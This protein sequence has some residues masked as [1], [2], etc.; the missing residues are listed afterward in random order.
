M[1]PLVLENKWLTIPVNRSAQ[2]S[3]LM[4]DGSLPARRRFELIR[5]AQR[6][7]QL[8]VAELSLQFGVSADTIRR[9]LDLLSVHGFCNSCSSL[10][11]FR[12]RPE[13]AN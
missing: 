9:D 5:L 8:S 13:K 10:W 11:A 6:Q 3:D 12:S 2:A 1:K 4:G 7:G